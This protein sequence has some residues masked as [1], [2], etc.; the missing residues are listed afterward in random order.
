MALKQYFYIVLVPLKFIPKRT[1]SFWQT[2]KI[3]NRFVLKICTGGFADY[4]RKSRMPEVRPAERN[5][6]EQVSFCFI[7]R[8]LQMY[9]EMAYQPI[10]ILYIRPP[11][12]NYSHE[13]HKR[14]FIE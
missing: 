10:F 1:A 4:S 6:L 3:P 11:V 12:I 2:I 5:K 8:F 14:S 9:G 13:D 7:Y